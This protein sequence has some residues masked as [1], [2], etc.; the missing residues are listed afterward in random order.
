MYIIDAIIVIISCSTFN[1]VILRFCK[2][3]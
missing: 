2:Q 1:G 3:Q